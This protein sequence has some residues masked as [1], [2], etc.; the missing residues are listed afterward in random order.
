[1]GKIA[2]LFTGQGAQSVGMG[3]DLYQTEPKAESVFIMGE[4]LREG[5]LDQC[6]H[7]NPEMLKQTKNTQP[8][9]FLMDLACARVLNEYGIKADVTVGFSLGEIAA[10]AYNKILTDEEAFKLVT[11]RGEAM[12][13]CAKKHPGAMVAVLRVDAKK[14]EELCK[15][16]NMLYPVNYNC[17]GQTVVAGCKEQLTVFAERVKET[18]GRAVPL[19]VSGAFHTPY[20]REAS[21]KLNDMLKTFHLKAP[22]IPLI[23]NTTGKPYPQKEDAIRDLL[24]NQAS[25]SVQFEKT[26]YYL[27]EMGVDTFI[28]VGAGKTLSGLVAKTLSDVTILNVC[29]VDSLHKT[30]EALKERKNA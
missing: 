30:V 4:G 15:E 24:A 7:G 17:P 28:E 9:L 22:K 27:K 2:F 20:M 8:C 5:T 18:G 12:D 23:A 6:F 26:L 1:M 11:L 29:D 3:Y 14:V 25:N 16:F 13:E 19:A 10:V 21:E